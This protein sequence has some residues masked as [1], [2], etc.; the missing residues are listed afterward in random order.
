MLNNTLI[1]NSGRS[2][3]RM[4]KGRILMP[5][6]PIRMGVNKSVNDLLQRLKTAK[7]RSP[8]ASPLYLCLMRFVLYAILIYIAYVF[9]FRLVIPVYIASRKIKKGF[10]EMQQKMQEQQASQYQN[11]QQQGYRP[12]PATPNPGSKPKSGDY[13]EFEEIK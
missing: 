3:G 13:I 4:I 7:N 1:I 6:L 11:D 10:R 2:Q 8:A 12:R 9:I 5:S